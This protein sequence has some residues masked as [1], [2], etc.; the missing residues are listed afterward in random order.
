LAETPV[1]KRVKF[2]KVFLVGKADHWL[3][4]TG[5]N[6]NSLTWPE[7]AA[8]IT[9]RFATETSLKLIDSFRHMEQSASLTAYTD[10]FEIMGKLKI[11]NPMLPNEYFIGCFI[12][13]LK[14]HIK[15]PLR[16]HNTS[17][18]VQA[19]ALARN[20]ETYNQR[21][22]GTKYSKWGYKPSYQPRAVSAIAKKEEGDSK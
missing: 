11:Q 12:S 20:Y 1:H 4:S 7:F 22:P 2:A 16:S 21:K 15:V 8:L 17:S 5:I 14:D 13:R 3:R 6:T 19:Y 18:L 10:G 9:S